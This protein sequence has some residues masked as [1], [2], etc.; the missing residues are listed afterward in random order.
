MR[1]GEVAH[2]DN[3]ELLRGLPQGQF[4]LVYIDPPYA[5]GNS[6]PGAFADAWP[7]LEAYLDFLVPRLGAIHRVLH[8]RGSLLVQLDQAAAHYVKV[9]LDR[10][11]GRERFRGQIIW[12]K[13]RVKKAQSAGFPRLHDILLWYSRSARFCYAHQHTP[14]APDYARSHYGARDLATGR[15]YQL[16]SLIQDG[17]GPPRRFG[18][19]VLAP[20]LGKHWIWS[21]E[22]IDAAFAAGRIRFTKNGRP[23]LVRY[24]D[25]ARGNVIGDVWTDIPP[26]NSQAAERAGW[27]TQKP[28]ALVRRIVLACSRPG[29]WVGDFFCGSGTTGVAAAELGRRFWLCDQSAAAVALARKRLAALR[30]NRA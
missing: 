30:R 11:F 25:E 10:I 27:P 22:R 19:Q 5:S 23:R 4:H 29:D 6:Y 12:Q 16:V 9:E 28:V 20:P 7:S 8:P 1:S 3:L 21:Q 2:G 26:V 17:A 14:L 24:L 13:V 18:D 15:R